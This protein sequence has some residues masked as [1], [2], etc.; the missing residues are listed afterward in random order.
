MHH[1][2]RSHIQL[3]HRLDL[4]PRV[5]IARS[6]ILRPKEPA[7]LPS[8]PVELNRSRGRESCG[9]ERTEDLDEVDGPAAVVVGT[10]R[11]AAR[12]ASEVDGVHVCAENRYRSIWIIG[13]LLVK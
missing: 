1:L 3:H 9:E 12:R 7:F 4:L 10:W 6:D 2:L 5:R 8:I 13:H 11:A